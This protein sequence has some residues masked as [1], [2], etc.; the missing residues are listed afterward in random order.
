[1]SVDRESF[2]REQYA[3]PENLRARKSAYE[4]AEGDDPRQWAFEAV[5]AAKPERVLEVG[6]G[7]GEL[8]ERLIKELGVK[9]V[10]I[11]QSAAMVGVQRSKG[12]DARATDIGEFN[13][14][15]ENGE[16]VLRRHFASVERREAVGSVTMDDET[17]RRFGASW[18]ALGSLV[19]IPPVGRPV[20][21]RRHSTVFVARK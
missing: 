8:A 20:S 3:T 9:L 16:E 6:G 1:L 5:A 11:D 4:N 15:S 2:V 19:E 14:R 21:V 7:E 13:F 18:D 12:I 17:I 10:G